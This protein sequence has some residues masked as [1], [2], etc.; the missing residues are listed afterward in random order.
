MI[1]GDTEDI[2]THEDFI[3]IYSNFEDFSTTQAYL[4]NSM[5]HLV[6]PI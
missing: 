1:E 6:Q 4:E 5:Q 2:N 3:T